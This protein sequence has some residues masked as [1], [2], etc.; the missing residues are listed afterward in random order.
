[1]STIRAGDSV[2]CITTHLTSFA[3]LVDVHGSTTESHG[4]VIIM[5]NVN[6]PVLL[7]VIFL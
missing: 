6:V 7:T 1:M 4:S 3:V 5:A 2:E